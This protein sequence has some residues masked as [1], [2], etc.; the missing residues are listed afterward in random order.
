MLDS[1]MRC[2]GARAA[3]EFELAIPRWRDDPSFVMGLILSLTRQHQEN[4]K[5]SSMPA[6]IDGLFDTH[7]P[8]MGKYR[9]FLFR[10]LLKVYKGLV[11][12][13]ENLK[14]HLMEGYADLRTIIMA[15]G[16]RFVEMGLLT[17]Q[18]DIFFLEPQEIESMENKESSS[19][20]IARIIAKRALSF[21]KARGSSPPDLVTR[22]GFEVPIEKGTDNGLRGIGCSAGTIT[23]FAR[24]ILD[25]ADAHELKPGEILVTRYT[26][27]GWTPLF[28]ICKG[29]VTEAGGILS[30][31]ATVAREYG[32]PAVSSLKDATKKIVT[33]DL[34]IVD[35]EAGKVI[36][37]AKAID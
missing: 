20:S 17:R 16:E 8:G 26:D 1:F 11:A 6:A 35:G 32:I 12:L 7:I 27:P 9:G 2:N 22:E 31:G 28:L 21:A 14:Y 29:I 18:E 15:K 10:S 23:G 5:R 33:G 37:K 24:V 30:H 19:E 25:I 34:L 36:V 13:R 4:D 3:G